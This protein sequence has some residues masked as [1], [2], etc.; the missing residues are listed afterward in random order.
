MPKYKLKT[1]LDNPKA[2]K[3]YAY[4]YKRTTREIFIPYRGYRVVAIGGISSREIAKEL[5]LPLRTVQYYLKKLV[6]EGYI[7]RWE[8]RFSPTKR[9]V[10]YGVKNIPTTPICIVC[11]E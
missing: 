11:P 9:V 3:I 6:K 10:R 4:I 7:N 5:G 8:R 2:C 1:I